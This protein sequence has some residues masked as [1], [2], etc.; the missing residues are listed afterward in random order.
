MYTCQNCR[1]DESTPADTLQILS[2]ERE[3][4]KN[5][6]RHK[7]T[8]NYSDR[9]RNCSFDSFLRAWPVTATVFLSNNA[10]L[11]LALLED[12][13]HCITTS[14]TQDTAE[15]LNRKGIRG[16]CASVQ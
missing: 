1:H 8:D 12:A 13:N 16:S 7:S 10:C 14:Q 9:E 4:W 15:T 2:E 6:S 11:A 5:F 3:T